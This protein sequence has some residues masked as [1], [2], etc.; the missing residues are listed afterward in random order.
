MRPSFSKNLL[1]TAIV[2]TVAAALPSCASNDSSLYIAGIVARQ[3]GACVV[4]PTL[5]STL[6]QK[7]VLDRAF[8][9]EYIAA[10]LVGNQILERGSR[11]RVRTETSRVAL[12]GA[13]ITIEDAQGHPLVPKFSTIG[14]GLA[15]PSDGTSPGISAMFVTIIPSTVA[16][17]LPAGTVVSKVR[18][19]G[20]TLGGEDV[21]SS[22]LLY[23]IEICNGCLVTYPASDRDL[24]ADGTDYQCKQGTDS[25]NMDNSADALPCSLG[26]DLPVH[27]SLCSNV[28]DVC[29]SP[30]NNPYYTP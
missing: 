27:C 20:T 9:T 8:T 11:E 24:T 19:F 18:V 16:G 26:I 22:E 5:D 6:V 3:Q 7:G 4:K 2:A 15:D 17:Q 23:P 13:E 1:A 10:V 14:T 30:A 12:T 28:S 21:E 25:A 29:R